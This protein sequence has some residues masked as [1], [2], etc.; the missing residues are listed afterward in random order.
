MART[1]ITTADGTQ[2]VARGRGQVI[3]RRAITTAF[4]IITALFLSAAV[5][6]L[7]RAA[8]APSAPATT[9]TA[10]TSISMPAALKA[11]KK[12]PKGALN[13]CLAT[14]LRH[15]WSDKNTFT[16]EGRILVREC[17]SQYRGAELR[18]CL[19]QPLA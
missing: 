16:P 1:Y 12:A 2:F 8:I 7:Q 11:C 13:D 18:S 3:A 19:K 4:L 15:A 5:I 10:S 9:P 6:G 14:Y 17:F